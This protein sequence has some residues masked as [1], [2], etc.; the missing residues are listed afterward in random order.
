MLSVRFAILGLIGL[1]LNAQHRYPATGLVLEIDRNHQTVTVSHRDI[2]GLM[3][4]MAMA[5]SVRTPKLLDGLHAGDSV[6][7]TLAVDKRSS[8]I[9]EI[10][11]VA[12][13]S[14]ERDPVLA[15]RLKTMDAVVS[16]NPP[17]QLA[18]GGKTEFSLIDQDGR[19]VKLSEFAGKVVVIDFIYTR[20]PLP[21]YCFRLSNNFG[22]LQ[23]RFAGQDN[24]VLLTVTFDPV[25]DAP[26]EL[27]RYARTWKAD[28]RKWHFLTG[29]PAEIQRVCSLFGVQYWP[30]DGVYTHTLHTAVLDSEGNLA[31]N[32][33][34]NKFTAQQLGDLVQ[35]VMI[36]WR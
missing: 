27:A 25:H 11:V 16:G 15:G 33:E 3:G 36:G 20:C 5:F 2:P 4:A 1:S 28:S 26:E 14:A 9:D 19:A 13:D 12:F 6:A 23:K 21:D 22:R 7:F 31:A 8:W 35:T 10:R 34:G 30:D 29:S 32:L 18:I 17:T 24:L